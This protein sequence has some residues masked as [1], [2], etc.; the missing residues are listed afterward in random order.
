M[1]R[2]DLITTASHSSCSRS[3]PHLP[4]FFFYYFVL[5]LQITLNKRRHKDKNW[6]T[7]QDFILNFGEKKNKL[8]KINFGEENEASN[9]EISLLFQDSFSNNRCLQKF[10]LDRLSQ[11]APV[12]WCLVT[13]PETN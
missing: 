11:L 6:E 7:I 1:L 3:T 13:A 5:P 12:L 9:T 8:K 4:F 10:L 2:S